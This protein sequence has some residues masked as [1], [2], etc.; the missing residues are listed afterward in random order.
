MCVHYHSAVVCLACS[1]GTHSRLAECCH[2]VTVYEACTSLVSRANKL[3]GE[4]NGEGNDEWE[5]E[6]GGNEVEGVG[7]EDKDDVQEIE[8]GLEETKRRSPFLGKRR[9]PFLG[10]RRAPF[11]GKRRSP[12]LGKRRSPFLGKR[13][14]GDPFFSYDAKRKSAFLRKRRSPFLGK[15]VILYPNDISTY[16]M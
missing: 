12:F 8:T 3:I 9:S 4:R 16:D 2:D 13:S 15:R 11:L 10:K 7:G 6:G 5:Q 14:V 1:A